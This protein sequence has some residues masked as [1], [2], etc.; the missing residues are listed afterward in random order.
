[1]A[2]PF[3]FETVFLADARRLASK[4][5]PLPA[6]KVQTWELWFPEAAANGLLF[7]RARIDPTDELWVHARPR[8]SPSTSE[9]NGMFRWR[10]ANLSGAPVR[11][12]R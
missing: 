7:A 8:P 12:C 1:M 3:P 11:S 4:D 5:E 2:R 10:G 9:T 6:P